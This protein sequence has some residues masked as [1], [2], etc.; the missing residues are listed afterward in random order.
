MESTLHRYALKKRWK[1]AADESNSFPETK[2]GFST[3]SSIHYYSLSQND[4][5]SIEDGVL[6]LFSIH[7]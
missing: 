5:H 7:E 2:K 6:L 1:V 3:V 4:V